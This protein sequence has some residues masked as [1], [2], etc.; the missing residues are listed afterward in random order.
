LW[1]KAVTY[2]QQAGAKALARWA[3]RE[4]VGAFE[5]A[6]EALAH[7]PESRHTLEQAIDLR[8]ALRTALY[9]SGDWERILAHLREAE[10]LA[11]RNRAA[12]DDPRRLGQVL[13]SLAH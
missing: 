13:V 9:P 4:T 12:L 2:C 7:L 3:Y 10:A 5:Q 8:L 6:L 1:D 11:L